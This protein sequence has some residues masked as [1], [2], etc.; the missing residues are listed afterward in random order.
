MGD[1]STHFSEREFKC[2]CGC[3]L[4]N[5]KGRLLVTLDAIREE[6][7]KE[8]NVGSGCRCEA[9][10]RRWGGANESGHLT[11]EAADIW[12]RGMDNHQLGELIKRM[13][14]AGRLPL[15]RYCY[16]VKG[17]TGTRVHV[18][19]DDKRRSRIFAF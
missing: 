4:M 8:V 3:G 1:L 19:V 18:G 13:H 6:V 2:G 12:V 5:A 9:W 11:G 14:A 10:N 15:L 7:G 16:L 17:T